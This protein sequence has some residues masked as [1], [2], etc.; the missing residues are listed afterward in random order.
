MH[1]AAIPLDRPDP[2]RPPQTR[3]AFSLERSRKLLAK[4]KASVAAEQHDKLVAEKTALASE[5][6]TTK[7]LLARV[8]ADL[9]A[10]KPALDKAT[11]EL[12]AALQLQDRLRKAGG[13][14]KAQAQEREKV[15][16][17]AKP[18]RL[19]AASVGWEESSTCVWDRSIRGAYHSCICSSVQERDAERTAKLAAEEDARAA[20]AAATAAT[21]KLT[22][23]QA[24]HEALGK[25]EAQLRLDLAVA[26]EQAAKYMRGFRAAK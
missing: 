6:A 1:S 15:R 8:Q 21:A 22:E 4:D 13:G 2:H 18:F 7:A 3:P 10:Q 14:F 12:Q 17:Q 23:L 5:L 20:T 19:W 25:T 9:D 24:T 11:G 26:Q 16:T